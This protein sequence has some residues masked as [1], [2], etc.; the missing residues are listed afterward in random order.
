MDL[1]V[2][3]VVDCCEYSPDATPGRTYA[4]THLH[5]G[6]LFH[7]GVTAAQVS[8]WITQAP[9]LRHY[10]A[11][12]YQDEDEGVRLLEA[13]TNSHLQTLDLTGAPAM[14][15][16]FFDPYDEGRQLLSQALR[17]LPHNLRLT[18]FGFDEVGDLVGELL[19]ECVETF[20]RNDL[21]VQLPLPGNGV[22]PKL[23]GW[24]EAVAPLCFT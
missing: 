1:R 15:E 19:L 20:D 13:A 8:A 23:W 12:Y 14:P 22:G 9:N 4:L 6:C 17:G 7:T 5:L 24:D 11:T 3:M 2:L 18:S 21:R 10:G 16:D